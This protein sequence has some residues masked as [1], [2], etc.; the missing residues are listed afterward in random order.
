MTNSTIEKSS[1]DKN[2]HNQKGF[3]FVLMAAFMVLV[4]VILLAKMPLEIDKKQTT[5]IGTAQKIDAIKRAL[6]IY[7]EAN[8][9]YL[10]CGA[11]FAI[12]TVDGV[13]GNPENEANDECTTDRR[14]VPTKALKL[15]D[16]YGIDEW[17]NRISYMVD[18]GGVD[19]V[20]T[21]NTAF[22][23]IN[24]T[25]TAAKGVGG[26]KVPR[27]QAIIISHGADGSGAYP[28]VV[29]NDLAVVQ[30]CNNENCDDND[31]IFENSPD[32]DDIVAYV[33]PAP[34]GVPDC[35]LW[36]DASKNDT[37]M[38]GPGDTEVA[39]ANAQVREWRNLCGN[40]RN[41]TA[42]LN[43]GPAYS[44]NIA[45]KINNKP[46][47]NFNGTSQFLQIPDFDYNRDNVE[48]FLVG[49]W[50]SD[51]VTAAEDRSYMFSQY[52]ESFGVNTI[53]LGVSL[54]KD[55]NLM[56]KLRVEASKDGTSEALSTEENT[57]VKSIYA[58]L[59]NVKFSPGKIVANA[60]GYDAAG[61]DKTGGN[62]TIFNSS[63]N[64]LIGGRL[65]GVGLETN[66]P[67]KGD[68]AEIL[69]FDK[70]LTSEQR[71]KVECGLAR[72]WGTVPT[73]GLKLWLDAN[74]VDGDGD[75][76]DNP[77]D[78]SD[79]TTWYDKSGNNYDVSSS[80]NPP[81]YAASATSN[82]KPA[83]RFDG[84]DDA[85]V[86]SDT[87]MPTGAATYFAVAK[88]TKASYSDPEYGSILTYGELDFNKA[89]Y[90][91]FGSDVNFGT[92]ALGVSQ[93]GDSFG[94]AS[95]LSDF[96]ILS[97]DKPANASP[98][99]WTMWSNG[100]S[101]SKAMDTDT[102]LGGD[103]MLQI[104]A[105]ASFLDGDIAEIL[106]YNRPLEPG[107]RKVAECYLSEKW[108]VPITQ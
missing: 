55:E 10:P 71:Q 70:P 75:T 72:K 60:F 81:K 49:K 41:A 84:V 54:Y 42:A 96:K 39:V 38:K 7:R 21:G 52:N 30:P 24:S 45:H 46:V 68:V 19:N 8:N 44:T 66:S 85:L 11:D 100:V 79:I 63:S 13:V 43:V 97:V 35:V 90:L 88:S 27:Y 28:K 69:M 26:G 74:D 98:A 78:A 77:P 62:A 64:L 50:D 76:T 105:G 6:I 73:K 107:E 31:F 53:A 104:G 92:D 3:T 89:V 82:S 17:G 16:D 37:I 23:M 67:F 83:I 56:E 14:G 9:G 15:P 87:G 22:S 91:A 59:L 102:A 80:G 58:N 5:T 99:T 33:P 32:Q 40:G 57:T 1:L 94:I 29:G 95:Q 36:F 86:R 20:N 34:N 93:H 25:E 108:G 2:F 47:L 65:N 61:T 106:I 101:A 103:D 18:N 48:L 51:S 4:G 12:S